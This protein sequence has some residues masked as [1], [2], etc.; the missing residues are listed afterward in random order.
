MTPT[1]VHCLPTMGDDLMMQI[2]SRWSDDVII[3]HHHG[4]VINIYSTTY[5][6]HEVH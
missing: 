1:H 5:C 3:A 2:N 4:D 6:L